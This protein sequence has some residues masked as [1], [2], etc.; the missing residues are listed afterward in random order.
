MTRK[1]AK[2]FLTEISYALG[3]MSVEYLTE[4]DGER[5]REA[6]KVLEQEP[7]EDAIS[8]QAVLD[9]IENLPPVSSF[10][11]D[12]IPVSEKTPKKEGDYLVTEKVFFTDYLSHRYVNV[13]SYALNLYDVSKYAFADKKRSG[14][15]VRDSECHFREIDVVAW[16]PCFLPE[17]Y[18]IK[19]SEV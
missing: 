18:Y 12:W 16:M 9:A 8:R 7:C 1:E 3:N 2:D 19:E 11:C 4:K 14:W 17:P 6:I 13:A 10:H 15:Y 5:M